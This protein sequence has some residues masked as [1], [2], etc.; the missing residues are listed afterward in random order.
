MVGW[1]VIVELCGYRAEFKVTGT[2][3]LMTPDF[4]TGLH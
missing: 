4:W 2:G 1:N 3:N